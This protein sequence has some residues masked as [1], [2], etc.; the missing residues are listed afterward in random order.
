MR[1]QAPAAAVHGSEGDRVRFRVIEKAPVFIVPVFIPYQGVYDE[2]I[3]KVLLQECR[4][5]CGL[6]LHDLHDVRQ[7]G[8][9]ATM[10]RIDHRVLQRGEVLQNNSGGSEVFAGNNDRFHAVLSVNA[11]DCFLGADS[12]AV[13]NMAAYILCNTAV[14]MAGVLIL[15]RCCWKLQQ[16]L[17]PLIDHGPLCTATT[18]V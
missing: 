9:I 15:R 17:L 12:N 3:P 10:P 1:I 4:Q 18:C 16:I 5:E 7:L 11:K 13:E 2:H 6:H 14:G 8:T